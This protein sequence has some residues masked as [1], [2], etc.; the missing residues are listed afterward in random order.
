MSQGQCNIGKKSGFLCKRSIKVGVFLGIRQIKRAS[1]WTSFLLILIM[2][3]TF[4]N[5]VI[6]N[7]IL[8][9]LVEG[10]SQTYKT[11]YSG[12]V[13]I[14]KPTNKLYIQRGEL[15]SKELSKLDKIE[16]FSTR[17]IYRTTIISDNE[18][19]NRKPYKKNEASA[20]LTGIDPISENNVTNLS[21]LLVEGEY[22]EEE[23]RVFALVGSRLLYKYSSDLPEQDSLKNVE[24]GD[25]I[26]VKIADSL[27]TFFVKGI[28]KS[29]IDGVGGRIYVPQYYLK[30]SKAEGLGKVGEIAIKIKKGFTPE[31]VK[32]DI[33]GLGVDPENA[34]V[35]T[36][37]E[38][39][40]K[41]FKDISS[42]FDTLGNVIGF[43]SIIVSSIT[44]FI[45]IFINALN[46]KKII[47]VMKGIG[48]C[49]ASIKISYIFQ[50]FFYAL[51]GNII[52]LALLYLLIKP[53]I[54]ANPIDFP[55]SDGILS[56]PLGNVLFRI[57]I[58]L[59]VTI[60]ASYLPAR[61]IVKRNTL[62][63]I[64]GK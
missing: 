41:F 15:L 27:Q 10:S 40:G 19:L 6:V 37:E 14:K 42:T 26:S 62:D 7:G 59:L 36:W 13:L 60:L 56:A 43:I 35:Q 18:N 46:R 47:G 55:F 63:S 53:Y 9:G 52:G 48:T 38:S 33:L 54:T 61:M 57:T 34:L 17:Y 50:S 11:N 51:V 39:Q 64:L 30:N 28:V 21:D 16:A 20:L 29:K 1:P 4:L 2:L 32:E 49:G 44:I 3:F 31:E 12:D 45:M 8:L 22:L 25:R 58:L 5:V 23:D 24:I